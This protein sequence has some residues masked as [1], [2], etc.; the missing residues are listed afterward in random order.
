MTDERFVPRNIGDKISAG[1]PIM[2]DGISSVVPV[3]YNG[4]D[5]T[6]EVCR[7]EQ[8]THDII[9]SDDDYCIAISKN[10]LNRES[11]IDIL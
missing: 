11:I 9:V 4:I 5:D 10:C 6:F 2:I 8:A 1:N 7:P 3:R